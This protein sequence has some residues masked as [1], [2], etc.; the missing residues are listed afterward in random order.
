MNNMT[1]VGISSNES[2]GKRYTTLHVVKDFDDYQ[3]SPENGR[4]CVGQ[5]VEAYAPGKTKRVRR[6]FI[7][8]MELFLVL[9][10]LGIILAACIGCEKVVH[11]NND[12]AECTRQFKSDFGRVLGVLFS[13]NN[14]RHVFD[15]SLWEHFLGILR[16]YHHEAF[17]PTWQARFFD[18]TPQLCIF[19]VPNRELAAGD[20]NRL[21]KLLCLKFSQ[22]LSL[23]GLSWRLF[24]EYTILDGTISVN[25]FYAEFREDLQPFFKQYHIAV[26]RKATGGYG[27]LHDEE[28][29]KEVNYARPKP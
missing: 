27:V 22:Y 17:T 28:L 23:Y 21:C 14:T 20:L 1:I 9:F 25:L 29:D 7:M 12:L 2:G 8:I 18:G 24:S 16:E 3:N 6:V 15:A 26:R 11:P 10:S 19:F 4:F 13:D 5:K